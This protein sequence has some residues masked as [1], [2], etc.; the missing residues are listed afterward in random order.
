[1]VETL[2]FGVINLGVGGSDP[3][4]K[5]CHFLI[6]VTCEWPFVPF[7]NFIRKLFMVKNLEKGI[8]LFLNLKEAKNLR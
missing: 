7:R 2:I 1:M 5:L 3:Y 6:D 4:I 8:F